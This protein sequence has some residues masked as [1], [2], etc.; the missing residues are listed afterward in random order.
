MIMASKTTGLTASWSDVWL[1]DGVR[2]PFADYNG[3]LAQVSPTDLGIKVAREAFA[4]WGVSPEEVGA[5][6]TGSVGRVS[7]GTYCLPRHMGLYSGV[8][9]EVPGHMVQRVC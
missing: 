3:A 1:L 5:V 8:P 9:I 4:R 2:T 7:F 6:I